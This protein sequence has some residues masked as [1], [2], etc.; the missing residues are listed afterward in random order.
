VAEVTTVRIQAGQELEAANEAADNGDYKGA[1][2][3]AGEARRL[4]VSTDDPEL[5]IRTEL[6]LGNIYYGLGQKDKGRAAF[7]SAAAEADAGSDA[8]MQALCKLYQARVEVQEGMNVSRARDDVAALI[9]SLKKNSLDQALAYRVLGQADK[10][11]RRYD[12]AA[13]DLKKALGIHK[14]GN[15]LKQAAYDNYLTASVYSIAGRY[16]DAIPYL[17]DALSMDRRSENTEG[18]AADWKALAEVYGKAGKTGLAS[19]AAA[20]AKEIEATLSI[21]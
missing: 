11:L 21:E 3:L 12:Q 14:K 6:A 18:L 10:S 20:R 1:L 17:E 5:R 8:V 19:D 7:A 9:S 13:A 16:D 2:P 4:A 15:Y